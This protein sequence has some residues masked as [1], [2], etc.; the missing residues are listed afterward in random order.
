MELQPDKITESQSILIDDTTL[1]ELSIAPQ[2]SHWNEDLQKDIRRN[3]DTNEPAGLFW[4]QFVQVNST[5]TA[6]PRRSLHIA[7]QP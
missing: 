1:D 4:F 5:L 6:K 7:Q 3:C 2:G